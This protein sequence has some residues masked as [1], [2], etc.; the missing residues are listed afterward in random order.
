[1]YQAR[2]ISLSLDCIV[3]EIKEDPDF[4]YDMIC[5]PESMGA[6]IKLSLGVN[7]RTL[8]V[9]EMCPLWGGGKDFK[10]NWGRCHH[11][12]IVILHGKVS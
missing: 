8:P 10:T 1:L 3:I 9:N 6:L 5:K 11:P 12:I 7:L 2:A 4:K